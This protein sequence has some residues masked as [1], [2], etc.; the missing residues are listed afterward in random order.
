MTCG[1]TWAVWQRG[2][3]DDSRANSGLQCSLG[4]LPH[5]LTEPSQPQG[6]HQASS[7]TC[8][9]QV[10]PYVTKVLGSSLAL[11]FCLA[12][13]EQPVVRQGERN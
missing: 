4:S 11:P 9:A 1:Q 12:E 6:C 7:E 5:T 10:L 13:T 8:N 3:K 2:A